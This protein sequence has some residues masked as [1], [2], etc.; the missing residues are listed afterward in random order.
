MPEP[1]EIQPPPPELQEFLQKEEDYSERKRALLEYSDTLEFFAYDRLLD[2]SILRR[3]VEIEEQGPMVYV[4][5]H[6]LAF[7]K[8]RGEEGKVLPTIKRTN[9][10][11]DRV[12]GVIWEVFT[13]DWI[14]LE[15]KRKVP[16]RYFLSECSVKDR[17][18]RIMKALTFKV[19]RNDLPE[20]SPGEEDMRPITEAAHRRGLPDDYIRKL[21]EMVE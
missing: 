18:E 8:A 15:R 12:W 1:D 16:R 6:R 14:E 2:R 3:R 4:P 21:H 17:G 19:S 5:N 7:V 10:P 11:G 9:E 13:E 20:V